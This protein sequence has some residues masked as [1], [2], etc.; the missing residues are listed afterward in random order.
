M[1]VITT[2]LDS[3]RNTLIRLE[4]TIIFGMFFILFFTSR[5]PLLI[6][7]YSTY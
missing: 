6:S 3:L 4:D 7:L 2:S 1:P 5:P